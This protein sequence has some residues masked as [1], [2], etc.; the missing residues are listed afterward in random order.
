MDNQNKLLPE[1]C[2]QFPAVKIFFDTHFSPKDFDTLQTEVIIDPCFSWLRRIPYDYVSGVFQDNNSKPFPRLGTREAYLILVDTENTVVFEKMSGIESMHE[3][4][5]K[6]FTLLTQGRFKYASIISKIIWNTDPTQNWVQIPSEDEE[7]RPKVEKTYSKNLSTELNINVFK[8]IFLFWNYIDFSSDVFNALP[9]GNMGTYKLGDKEYNPHTIITK[10]LE[11][12]ANKFFKSYFAGINTITSDFFSKKGC[13]IAIK[14]MG[15]PNDGAYYFTF[16]D[17]KD[18]DN[19][20]LFLLNEKDQEKRLKF[21]NIYG[22][23]LAVANA[24]KAAQ[25]G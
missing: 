14:H 10:T 5:K 9:K 15:I 18:G 7:M 16:Y 23:F 6:L 24:M 19:Y 20:A 22:N 1:F 21:I 8:S 17:K 12:N 25:K 13:Y 2:S 3:F 11:E 4:L